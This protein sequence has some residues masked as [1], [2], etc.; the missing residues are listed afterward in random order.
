MV[1]SDIM[2]LSTRM[3]KTRPMRTFLTVLGVSVGIGAVLFLVSLGYGLQ[4][5]VLNE[6]TTADSL[7]TLD[8]S[9]GAAELLTLSPVDVD[10]MLQIPHVELVSPVITL[11]TQVTVDNFTGSNQAYV[12]DNTFFR[13]SGVTV[14][15]GQLPEEADIHDVVM[16]SAAVKLFGL[17]A[18]QII[19]QPLSLSF[20]IPSQ[21]LEGEAEGFEVA[22]REEPYRVV[23]VIEDESANYLFVSAAALRDLNLAEY[24][25][26]KVK[27]D[28]S[29]YM[30]EVRDRIIEKGFLVSSLSDTIEQT[31]KIFQIIQIVLAIFGLIALVVSAIGMVN[32]MTIALLERINEIGIMRAIGITKKDIRIIFLVESAI[33][34]FLGGLGGIIVGFLGGGIVNLGI[35]LLA[36]TFGGRSLDLFYCPA[37]F[38]YFIIIFSTVIGLT[39]GI[40]PSIKASKLNPLAAL[41]YK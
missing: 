2:A 23:G 3:F 6:I 35:N 39:T 41:R 12:I 38:I 21:G 20:F 30:G 11:N 4:R 29:D 27:V 17:E 37:W 28:D 9:S 19:N 26:V 24:D 36:K 1:I 33:M 16:S 32:T 8:V 25:Q 13:L 5:V 18:E 14:D 34:G 22:K 31:N 15:Y 10:S 7:L 40:Y